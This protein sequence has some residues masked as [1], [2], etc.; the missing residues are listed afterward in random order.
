MLGIKSDCGSS[1]LRR[2]LSNYSIKHDFFARY[3]YYAF[4]YRS[5]HVTYNGQT[6]FSAHH[7]TRR[8][9]KIIAKFINYSERDQ[10]DTLVAEIDEWNK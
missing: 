7:P 3:F 10:D 9:A 8:E 1:D 4:R 6:I 5:V 2:K